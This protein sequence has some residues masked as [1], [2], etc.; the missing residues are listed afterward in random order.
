MDGWNSGS[1]LG[2][3][4]CYA[5]QQVGDPGRF[6]VPYRLLLPSHIFCD[7]SSVVAYNREKF[8]ERAC[9]VPDKQRTRWLSGIG[10]WQDEDVRQ[11][12]E[13]QKKKA[14]SLSL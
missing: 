3:T 14:P 13:I 1:S 7:D 9:A 5:R 12:G 8:A 4:G 6:S 10:T 2:D 11:F